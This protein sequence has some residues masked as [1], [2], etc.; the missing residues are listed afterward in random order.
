MRLFRGLLI[1]IAW[2]GLA[3]LAGC[4]TPGDPYSRRAAAEG[5]IQAT[6]TA[7]AAALATEMG[8]AFATQHALDVASQEA[9]TAAQSTSNALAA[10]SVQATLQAGYTISTQAVEM[11]EQQR[12]QAQ[13][14]LDAAQSTAVLEKLHVQETLTAAT[15]TAQAM[16]IKQAGE[17]EAARRRAVRQ[18]QWESFL[19]VILPLATVIVGGIVIVFLARVLW[20]LAGWAIE[21]IDRKRSFMETRWGAYVYIQVDGQ[22]RWAPVHEIVQRPACAPR[23]TNFRPANSVEAGQAIQ[24]APPTVIYV[25][26]SATVVA[27]KLIQ[28]A[29][30][31]GYGQGDQVPG[32]RKLNGW[33][34]GPWQRAIAALV[35]A[36]AIEKTQ[37]GNY[38]VGAGYE[39]LVD[40]LEDLR[41]ERVKL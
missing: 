31:Q 15:P 34:S 3:A 19:A 8:N 27:Q 29:V 17:A 40:L 6:Q 5:E 37:E 36:S 2:A 20:S 41:T 4:A 25:G 28:D 14:T 12:L 33:S 11:A 16:A 35:A 23:I 22:Y 13:L 38:L 7:D 24:P 18:D 10:Q 30:S 1:V 9:Q 39:C 32:W 21:W 26:R